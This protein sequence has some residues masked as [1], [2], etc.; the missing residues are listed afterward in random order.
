MSEEIT[1]LTVIS[2][3][4]EKLTKFEE[5]A[6]FLKAEVAKTS[7]I[8]VDDL[9]DEN[10]MDRVKRGRIDLRKI[11]KGIEDTGLGFRRMFTGINK[12]ISKKQDVLLAITSPEVK[13]LKNL[14]A[15]SEAIKTKKERL[16]VL[17]YRKEK[18]AE[19]DNVTSDEELLEMN[20]KQFSDYLMEKTEEHHNAEM[21]KEQEAERK[22]QYKI[23]VDNA[24]NEKV[25]K[26]EKAKEAVKKET[27]PVQLVSD[28]QTISG[29][30]KV[31]DV[32]E[33][34]SKKAD[35]GLEFLNNEDG[36]RINIRFGELKGKKTLV[37]E[38][39]KK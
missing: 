31:L 5:T 28:K 12:N 25:E 9:E 16:I 23:D 3:S 26:I 21:M 32:L 22:K 36:Y 2:E 15:E 7:N 27:P 30:Q 34:M 8:I 10:Q 35:V 24:V 20:D 29:A 14:E 33:D 4:V 1:K 13:R 39:I 38:I 11:E 19:V 6:E 37:F 17:P 18:L